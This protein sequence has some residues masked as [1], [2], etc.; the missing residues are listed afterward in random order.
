M[1]N[2]LRN[3]EREAVIRSLY[4][5]GKTL[6]EVG[7]VFG[8]TRERVRQILRRMGVPQHKGG[9]AKR[10]QIKRR[11]R[12]DARRVE[13][14]ARAQE[15][16]GCY[17]DELIA[18]NGGRCMSDACAPAKAY[19]DQRRNAE[20]RGIEWSITFPEWMTVWEESGHL[21]ERGRTGSKFVMGRRSDIGPY[22]RD[23]VY[24]T[25]LAQNAADYQ[26]ELKRR[27]VRC[28]DG[29]ARLPERAAA[30]NIEV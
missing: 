30:L 7:D 24:I 16:Y 22:D 10:T 28:S 23:N 1:A 21:A 20:R 6:Q 8:I 11:H 14:D 12:E 29:F 15:I 9:I 26:A 2:P 13:R 5:T 17:H 27:G 25:T 3:P 4:E 19:L 18:L